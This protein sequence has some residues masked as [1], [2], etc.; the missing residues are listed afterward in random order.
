[1]RWIG[2]ISGETRV[3]TRFLFFP[4]KVNSE[5][6]WLEVAKIHQSYNTK[7]KGWNNDWFVDK[8]GDN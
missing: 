2:R 4:L 5:W 6:R 7:A 1:M 8:K 3:I